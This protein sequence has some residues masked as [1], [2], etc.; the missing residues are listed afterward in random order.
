LIA[1][2]FLVKCAFTVFAVFDKII[3]KGTISTSQTRYPEKLPQR[4]VKTMNE[5]DWRL[6]EIL[7]KE[8]SINK[9]AGRLF[10]SQPSLSERIK[11]IE[12]EFGCR[13]VTRSPKGVIFTPEGEIL[14]RYAQNSLKDLESAKDLINNA[15]SR[16]RGTLR[17]GCSNIFAKYRLPE[18]LCVF[19]R[20]YPQVDVYVKTDVSQNIYNQLLANEAQI[21]IIRGDYAWREEKFLLGKDYFCVVSARPLKLKDLPGLPLIYHPTDGRL[22]EKIDAWW[23]AHF[24]EPPRIGMEVNNLHICLQMVAAGLG[25][26]MMSEMCLDDRPTL[27]SSRMAFAP[28]EFFFRET[29]VCL[30]PAARE[31]KLVDT[32]YEFLRGY[33]YGFSPA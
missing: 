3:T 11:Q 12:R 30:R 24:K 25:Y 14:A 26:A 29:W 13:I 16:I 17:I 19:L 18:I 5:K 10:L 20:Q 21:G 9:T 31:I 15:D 32:F 7:L 23:R 33:R 22:Q 1:I 4:R 6:L 2:P 8:K 28:G 27:C